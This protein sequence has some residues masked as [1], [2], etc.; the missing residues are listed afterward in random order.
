[1]CCRY[2][3][4]FPAAL[5]D[6]AEAYR[7][8][9]A[10]GQ[11][12]IIG[13]RLG[14]ALAA[15]LLVGLRDE[16]T[17]LPRCAALVSALLDLSMHAPSLRLNAAADPEVDVA[18]L[19]RQV[20]RHAGTTPLTD[21]LLSPLHANLHGLPP[22]QLL[23]AGNDVLLDDSVA[24]AARAARSGMTVDLRVRPTAASLRADGGPDMA[25]FIWTWTAPRR[26]MTCN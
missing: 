1:M 16:G 13:E 14:A 15:A 4:S 19:R 17:G 3:D 22:I 18:E 24:F 2:R 12:A 6:V 10:I 7:S 26:A 11:V 8:S 21:P 25:A 5:D 20:V 9:Q 23:T